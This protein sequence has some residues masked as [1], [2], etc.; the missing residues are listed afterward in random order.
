MTFI[1]KHM[2]LPSCNLAKKKEASAI[3]S[4]SLNLE[5]DLSRDRHP[6]WKVRNAQNHPDRQLVFSKHIAQ[7]LRSPVRHLRI[8]PR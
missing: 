8:R 3:A 7:Q 2:L 5:K 6:E 4:S 1:G